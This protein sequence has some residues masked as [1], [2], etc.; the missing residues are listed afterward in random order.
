VP[1]HNGFLSLLAGLAALSPQQGAVLG[2]VGLGPGQE[3]IPQFMGMLAWAGVALG[4][5][6]LWPLAALRRFL[7][8]RAARR[9]EQPAA[10]AARE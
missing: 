9:D 10:A 4:A 5:V 1:D 7:R 8:A 2:Y 3:F 6:L